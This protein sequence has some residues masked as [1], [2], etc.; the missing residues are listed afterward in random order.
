MESAR[1]E[2]LSW[3]PRSR[4][5]DTCPSGPR[6]D[7]AWSPPLRANA[8]SIRGRIDFGQI[9]RSERAAAG[10]PGVDRMPERDLVLAELQAVEQ[11]WPVALRW[12][13]DQASLVVA[14]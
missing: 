8:A 13:V 10:D 1:P 3:P 14:E 4:V 6:C 12:E 2:S 11:R 5:R 7:Q 9:P